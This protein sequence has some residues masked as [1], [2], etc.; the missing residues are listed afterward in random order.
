MWA[1]LQTS[2]ARP[3]SGQG[4]PGL[5]V[6]AAPCGLETLPGPDASAWLRQDLGIEGFFG[7]SP[8]PA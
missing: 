1:V 4:A 3:A 8:E 2:A 7:R 6:G 5:G